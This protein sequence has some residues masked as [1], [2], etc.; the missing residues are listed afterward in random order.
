MYDTH[1]VP[2]VRFDIVRTLLGCLSGYPFVSSQQ[3]HLT[4]Q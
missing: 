3:I 4:S 1:F 2:N